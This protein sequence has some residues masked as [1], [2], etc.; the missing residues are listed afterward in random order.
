MDRLLHI[1]NT[2][3]HHSISIIFGNLGR[4]PALLNYYL[5]YCFTSQETVGVLSAWPFKSPYRVDAVNAVEPLD[6]LFILEPYF[7]YT[8]YKP[9]HVKHVIVLS[10]HL[11]LLSPGVDEQIGF[12]HLGTTRVSS[13][14]QSDLEASH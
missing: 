3:R 5:D 9:A 2:C 12:L 7:G 1:F 10:S 4:H 11:C 13:S 14:Y 6:F 8:V